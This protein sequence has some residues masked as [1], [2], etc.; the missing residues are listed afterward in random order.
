[1][2][3]LIAAIQE[4]IPTPKRDFAVAPRMCIL[5]SFDVNKPGTEVERL[6]GGVVGGS[7]VQGV[8]KRGE[9]MEMTP[10]IEVGGSDRVTYGRLVG[11][12]ETLQ[13]AGGEV[14]QASR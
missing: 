13:A 11:N 4:K 8:F 9:E 5:R 6:L 1:M 12:V 14:K 7:V 2:D 10:G 3:V